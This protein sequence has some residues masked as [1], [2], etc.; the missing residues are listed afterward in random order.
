MTPEQTAAAETVTPGLGGGNADQL[1]F[2]EPADAA[3]P[4]R[5]HASF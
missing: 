4:A 1:I 2:G 5:P 3:P